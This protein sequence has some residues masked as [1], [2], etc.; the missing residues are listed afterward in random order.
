MSNWTWEDL[1]ALVAAEGSLGE[2]SPLRGPERTAG[3]ASGPRGG[4]DPL[5]ETQPFNPADNLTALFDLSEEFFSNI[6]RD[7]AA[8]AATG[9]KR[10]NRH[11][12][13]QLESW[14]PLLSAIENPEIQEFMRGI[15]GNFATGLS[16]PALVMEPGPAEFGVV[17]KAAMDA[18]PLLGSLFP[19]SKMAW[20]APVGSGWRGALEEI[21]KSRWAGDSV[22]EAGRIEFLPKPDRAFMDTIVNRVKGADWLDLDDIRI[23]SG[24]GSIDLFDSPRSGEFEVYLN[25]GADPDDL[26][27]LIDLADASDVTLITSGDSIPYEY[28]RR[29]GFVEEELG[30]RLVREPV[31]SDYPMWYSDMYQRL[32]GD[33]G[34]ELLSASGLAEGNVADELSAMVARNPDLPDGH[35][36][37]W[38]ERITD[39]DANNPRDLDDIINDLT[40]KGVIPRI[41]GEDFEP[42]L[43]EPRTWGDDF[44]GDSPGRAWDDFVNANKGDD[45]FVGA[46]GF[47]RMG[48]DELSDWARKLKMAQEEAIRRGSPFT[49]EEW[50]RFLEIEGVRVPTGDPNNPL[51]S[52]TNNEIERLHAQFGGDMGLPVELSDAQIAGIVSSEFG[53]P[54]SQGAI[55]DADQILHGLHDTMDAQLRGVTNMLRTATTH[56]GS[57]PQKIAGDI[58]SDIF[59]V[60]PEDLG[61]TGDVLLDWVDGVQRTYNLYGRPGSYN[62][63]RVVEQGLADLKVVANTP[64]SLGNIIQD[65]ELLIGIRGLGKDSS[66]QVRNL[67]EVMNDLHEFYPTVPLEKLQSIAEMALL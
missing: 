6:L 55:R 40:E 35:K 7:P 67:F 10:G 38:F 56:G 12:D 13:T 11:R 47:G 32:G 60:R 49:R 8:V 29:L 42:R 21:F 48:L 52:L 66:G 18:L 62:V 45:D 15:A 9:W 36:E 16:L 37:Y 20:N 30:G 22:Y 17:G 5:T 58:I 24:R 19:A 59:P 1:N 65:Y 44:G 4:F 39:A 43:V 31:S 25:P 14:E 41:P 50:G 64:D 33:E 57:L 34:G 51:R 27:R 23:Q 53:L 26:A 3:G 54:V 2:A 46:G 63:Q 28:A 61:R